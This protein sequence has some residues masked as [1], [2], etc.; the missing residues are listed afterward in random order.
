MKKDIVDAV[1][2]WLIFIVTAAALGT[3]IWAGFALLNHRSILPHI[4]VI[5][6]DHT[7][8]IGLTDAPQ[9]LDIRTDDGIAVQ[10]VLLGNVYETLITRNQSNELRPGLAKSWNISDDGLTYTFTLRSGVR[11]S[12]GHTMSSSDVVWSIQQAVQHG[13]V[14]AN[15][16]TNLKSVKN[17]SDDTVEITLSHT[18]PRLL[19][20]LS[21]RAGI[22]YDE[23]S[24]IDYATSSVGTG[25]FVVTDMSDGTITLQRNDDY[26]S[27]KAALSQILL[28]YYSDD[29]ALVAAFKHGDIQMAL[30]DTSSA[31]SEVAE[32]PNTAISSGT[33]FEK[34]LLGYNMSADSPFSDEQVRKMVRYA[35]SA[36]ALKSIADDSYEALGGPISP[37]EDGY[38]DLTGLFPYDLAQAKSMRGFFAPSYFEAF[39]F[40]VPTEYAQL[41]QEILEQLQALG[42]DVSMETLDDTTLQTRLQEGTYA[43][44]LMT[45]NEQ[46]DAEVFS[47]A[48]SVFHFE[49]GDAQQAWDTVMASTNDDDYKK[50]LRAYAR[51]VSDNAAADWLYTRKDYVIT[52]NGLAGYP[53][54]MTGEWLPLA[55]LTVQ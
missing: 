16:F 6:S 3:I 22:I 17:P 19:R 43:I 36:S 46:G 2:R 15:A 26:W 12:N 28:H 49:N 39:T 38:E 40:L 29:A 23:Q 33:G 27:G 4:D 10:R 51:I 41:G 45:M 47:N 21:G 32:I 7:V 13:F 35:V 50:N 42:F 30:P 9:S 52:S 11:F 44:A 8:T 25:P 31:I 14:C 37:L 55:D 1:K 20:A 48:Q 54:N 18:D 24:N 53:T 5:Q 34:V